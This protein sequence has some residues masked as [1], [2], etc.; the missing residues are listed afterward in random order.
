MP[1]TFYSDISYSYILPVY[2]CAIPTVL[3]LVYGCQDVLDNCY[4]GQHGYTDPRYPAVDVSLSV[5]MPNSTADIDTFCRYPRQ[6]VNN[7]DRNFQYFL[8]I[9]ISVIGCA[10]STSIVRVHV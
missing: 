3:G 10:T 4:A 9:D 1:T 8:K 5:L 6:H 7:P 2:V